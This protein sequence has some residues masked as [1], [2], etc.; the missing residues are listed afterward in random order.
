[1]IGTK[2]GIVNRLA[3][4]NTVLLAL[5]LSALLAAPAYIG[6]QPELAQDQAV[7]RRPMPQGARDRALG[8][9]RT[10][11]F[12]G[13]AK[14]DGVVSEK[15]FKM[16]L[17]QEVTPRFPDGLTVV[18]ADGQFRGADGV[19]VKENA[20]VLVLLYPAE[21]REESG[22]KIER[23]RRLYMTRFQQESVLRVDDPLGVW[24]SF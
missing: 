1:M 11:L 19:L 12:F 10:E 22:K 17:D 7:V 20:Y 6:A 21:A 8:F 14:P 24:V 9:G 2:D 18:D 13:T 16:F 15:E 4:K 3:L 23:I 5:P